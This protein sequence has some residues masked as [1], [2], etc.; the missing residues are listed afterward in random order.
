MREIIKDDVFTLLRVCLT[1][2]Q[3]ST[4]LYI[5]FTAEVLW[6]NTLT[7]KQRQKDA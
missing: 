2:N 5:F 3:R 4:A 1:M 7:Q 6:T